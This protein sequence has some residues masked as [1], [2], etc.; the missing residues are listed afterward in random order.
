MRHKRERTI[1]IMLNPEKYK[2]IMSKLFSG[3]DERTIASEEHVANSTVY[4]IAQ[5]FPLFFRNSNLED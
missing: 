5:S 4:K 1:G 2:S 3:K